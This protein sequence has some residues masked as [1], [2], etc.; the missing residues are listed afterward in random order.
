MKPIA[1]SNRHRS[2]PWCAITLMFAGYASAQ[3]LLFSDNFDTAR[4][5][6]GG[7]FSDFT[8]LT[9]DQAGTAGTQTYNTFI[10]NGGANY[11]YQ[12]GNG[13]MWLMYANGVH[14]GSINMRGSLNYDIAAAANTLGSPLEIKFNMSVSDGTDPTQW[15][16]FTVGGGQNPFVNDAG[17]G[18][19]SLFRDSGGTQ[20]FSNGADLGGAPTF[21]N[22]QVITFVLSDAAGT[23]SAFNSDGASDVVKM[24]VGTTLTN[25]FTGLDL[26]ATDQFISFHAGSTVAQI[27]N[28][29]ITATGAGP[30]N[31]PSS[32]T[33]TSTTSG[34]W[35]TTSNWLNDTLATG[36]GSTA[37]FSTLNITEDT[38]VNLD[39]ARTIGNLVFGDTDTT[40]LAGWTLTDNGTPSNI[41]IL[42]GITP[43]ITVN[44][45]GDSKTATISAAI[46]GSAG[47]TKSGPGTLTLTAANSYSGATTV[48][49]GTLLVSGQR[50]FN[51][52]R[53]TTVASG[54]V[55]ELNDSDN[56]FTT[57]I[58]TSTISGA[59]TFRLSGNSI[60]NQASNGQGGDR[61]NFAMQS[62]GLIDL[63]GTSSIVNGGWRLVS[64]ANNR[65]DMNIDRDATLDLWDGQ[66]VVVDALTGSGTITRTFLFFG[67]PTLSLGIDNGS[68]EFSGMIS[69]E[70]SVVK[71]G[72][73]AQTLSG[74]NTYTGNTTVN[75]G[76]LII[77]PSGSLRFRP[78]TDGVTNALTGVAAATLTYEGTVDF[79]LS[80]ANTTNGNAWTI[81]GVGS[82][83]SSTFT[84]AA[85]TSSLGAF[86]ETTPGTWELST[87]SSK[88]TFS[89][90]DG[91]LGYEVTATPYELW[92][93]SFN[94]AIGLPTEDDDN[95]GVTNFEEYAF[96]LAPDSGASTNPIASPLDKSTGNFS[97]TR[98]A[99]SGLSYSVWFS[100]DLSN[101]FEDT[102]ATEGATAVNGSVE[103]VPVTLSAL[104]GNQLP[105]KLFIQVRA[106]SIPPQ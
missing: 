91:S 95:D 59:G 77:S 4:D 20:Q 26:N 14:A 92:A 68:G 8:Y 34:P 96:G 51:V 87:T 97:Y 42:N 104:P 64:W 63:Q 49:G 60:I 27:D 71:N 28:L 65:A 85:V 105:A 10:D 38:T 73:G 22:G 70:I 84:P 18:F 30:T 33:W 52:G 103:T 99:A 53:T 25:T 13:G 12:R 78:T 7:A 2:L 50:Y 48:S 67:S 94:P 19:S 23:G 21:T 88:W 57:L 32:G 90:T 62:G 75:D 80:A 69:S 47:L 106:A 36:S 5:L 74:I 102:G 45:L 16:S 17:V 6:N 100:T 82:F 43:S 29:S 58:P 86:I 39:S 76:S 31:P 61:L 15:T 101:W 9:P 40:S 41:L 24:Y 46:V 1:K 11:A 89:T 44:A 79:D 93:S 98:R 54:A 83:D 81:V 35:G 72:S 66:D 3:T 56:T 37:D 55:L